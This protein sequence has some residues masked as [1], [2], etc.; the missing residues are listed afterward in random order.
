MTAWEAKNGSLVTS[1]S[2][3]YIW[4][5]C[6]ERSLHVP[7]K[8]LTYTL[9]KFEQ[10]LTSP[11]L[12]YPQTLSL[13]NQIK[14]GP[15]RARRET[16]LF[17]SLFGARARTHLGRGLLRSCFKNVL[18][19]R[20]VQRKVW[21]A[22]FLLGV[23]LSFAAAM[24]LDCGPLRFRSK[25]RKCMANKGKS[26]G[27]ELWTF[28]TLHKFGTSLVFVCCVLSFVIQ[29][30]W[31]RVQVRV[32]LQNL[33]NLS[34]WGFPPSLHKVA[35][36]PATLNSQ[37]WPCFMGPFG[38]RSLLCQCHGSWKSINFTSRRFCLRGH[39]WHELY[40]CCWWQWS[41]G[42]K[43]KV[44]SCHALSTSVIVP[45][46]HRL[47][48]EQAAKCPVPA[49]PVASM[50]QLEKDTFSLVVKADWIRSPSAANCKVKAFD[51]GEFCLPCQTTT[52]AWPTSKKQGCCEVVHGELRALSCMGRAAM[53]WWG[54]SSCTGVRRLADCVWTPSAMCSSF[55]F[56]AW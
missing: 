39:P 12:K 53:A 14:M 20:R 50:N 25:C 44:A 24:V 4:N 6:F 10:D 7:S 48:N 37:A 29:L 43:S 11:N 3:L 13:R 1:V 46:L 35:K 27:W 26:Y 40:F 33:K 41:H 45:S 42:L 17:W 49:A 2:T 31:M 23:V 16:N 22:L 54:S 36:T 18:D 32:K 47:I 21:G 15:A 34:F 5:F 28:C 30:H 9:R 52:Q 38:R 8:A 51:L 19:T 56:N 55:Q